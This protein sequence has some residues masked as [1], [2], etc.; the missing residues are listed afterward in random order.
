MGE[1]LEQFVESVRGT[2][3]LRVEHD[4]GDGFVRL[5][6][7]EAE[8]RQA[9]QDI[10][11]SEDIVLELMR[12]SRDA[13]AARIFIAM[14]KEGSKRILTVVDDGCGIPPAMHGHVF[15]SRVTSK[16]DTSQRDLWGLH[17][18]G[19]ALYSIAVN[20]QSARVAASDVDAGC[21]MRVETDLGSLPEKT[22]QSSFPTFEL[23]D[24]DTVNVR[25]PKN[26]LRTVC[27][28][29][30]DC[31]STCDV[32][33]GSPS[34]VASTLYLYGVATLSVIDRLFGRN[35]AP[36]P[37]TKRLAR[38]G[39]PAMLAEEAMRIGIE[40]SERTCRRIMDGQIPQLDP[41]L[42][43][44]VIAKARGKGSGKRAKDPHADARGLHLHPA[45]AA[46]LS[47]AVK[48]AFCNIARKYYLEQDVEPQ[49]RA[50]KDRITISIPVV[51]L[52]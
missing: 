12:N 36:I 24:G 8:R 9:V 11:S 41:V 45:D 38:A 26:I 34:E 6:T 50:R 2:G 42:E 1:T 39:D 10:R 47:K 17:G 20:A 14:S 28:F 25:G 4:F 31:R 19:M 33:V 15:E 35:D 43:R 49:V 16:L 48:G 40:L 44:V 27:E 52:L 46:D 5:H 22:D 3:H 32:Y 21:A 13:H 29:A 51:K 37:V 30:I 18:R 7:S 23:A